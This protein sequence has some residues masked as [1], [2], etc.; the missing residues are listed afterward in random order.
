MPEASDVAAA[1]APKTRPKRSGS[2]HKQRD[3][4][5]YELSSGII[6]DVHLAR[7][8][9]GLQVCQRHIQL[10]R[11]GLTIGAID[12]AHLDNGCLKCFD[13]ALEE[14]RIRKDSRRRLVLLIG[15]SWTL[16]IIHFVKKVKM[17]VLRKDVRDARNQLD[18]VSEQWI[19]LLRLSGLLLV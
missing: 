16:W 1:C 9:A 10:H 2:P 7:V 3:A 4:W 14:R 15:L 19:V 11:R 8:E 5:K 12:L 17:L 6:Y 13:I 18:S